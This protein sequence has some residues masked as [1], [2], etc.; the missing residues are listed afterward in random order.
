MLHTRPIPVVSPWQ[1]RAEP[2]PTVAELVARALADTDF[3]GDISDATLADDAANDADLAAEMWSEEHGD[4]AVPLALIRD[5]AATL[6]ERGALAL[7]ER[8]AERAEYEREIARQPVA[9]YA[10]YRSV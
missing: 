4:T 9:E 8:A 5:A 7:A 10:R 1:S 6:I 2:L 3:L